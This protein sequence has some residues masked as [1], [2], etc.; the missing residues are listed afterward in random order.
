MT[1]E[2][3]YQKF[4]QKMNE[5]RLKILQFLLDYSP[6]QIIALLGGCYANALWSGVYAHKE[7]KEEGTK[8]TLEILYLFYLETRKILT[9][10]FK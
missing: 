10:N 6:V 4:E 8:A 7:G 9:E 2:E 5:G 3:E 1:S